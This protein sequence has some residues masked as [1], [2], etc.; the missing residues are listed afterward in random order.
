MILTD[1]P[2]TTDRDSISADELSARIPEAHVTSVPKGPTGLWVALAA[3][4]TRRH[5]AEAAQVV[6]IDVTSRRPAAGLLGS[7]GVDVVPLPG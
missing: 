3:A 5:R 6:V 2:T 7:L 4:A 1:R